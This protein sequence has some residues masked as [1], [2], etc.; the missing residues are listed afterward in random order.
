MIKR[1]RYRIVLASGIAIL[2]LCSLTS[3]GAAKGQAG[4]F[5]VVDG[6]TSELLNGYN[7]W[8]HRHREVLDSLRTNP[9]KAS[10][11]PGYPSPSASSSPSINPFSA[12][13]NE[14]AYSPLIINTPSIDLYTPSGIS[15]LHSTNSVINVQTIRS[16]A[17]HKVP[18]QKTS[19]NEFRPTLREALQMFSSLK[20]FEDRI[21]GYV[22]FALTCSQARCD[23]QHQAI[24]QLQAKHGLGSINVIEVNLH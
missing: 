21:N 20:P 18:Q 19:L 1:I 5:I 3:L 13:Q 6:S 2:S 15:V 10:I 4:R 24:N 8:M 16:L 22:L 12:S 11:N 7:A 23:A 14:P 9:A 17:E